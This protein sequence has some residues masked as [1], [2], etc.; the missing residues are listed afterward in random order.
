M[1]LSHDRKYVVTSSHDSCHFWPSNLIPTLPMAP[2]E[3][4]GRRHRKKCKRKLKH[5]D[6]AT[7]KLSKMKKLQQK[8]F[9]ADLCTKPE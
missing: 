8:D 4:G 6:L 1:C 3:E 5:N 7:D 9:F 2:E